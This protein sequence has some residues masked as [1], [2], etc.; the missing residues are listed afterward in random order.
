M[1][2]YNNINSTNAHVGGSTYKIWFTVW[3]PQFFCDQL[4]TLHDAFIQMFQIKANIVQ[5]KVPSW[6]NEDS[7][8][9]KALFNNKFTESENSREK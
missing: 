1:S 7:I 6:K 8:N 2:K 5:R 3:E 9:A 4:Y